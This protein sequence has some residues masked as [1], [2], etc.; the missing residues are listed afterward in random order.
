MTCD[1]VDAKFHMV[2]RLARNWRYMKNLM[3]INHIK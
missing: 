2:I 3:A 1:H